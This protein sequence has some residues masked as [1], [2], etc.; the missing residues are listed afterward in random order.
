M[1]VRDRVRPRERLVAQRRE[2][3]DRGIERAHGELDA[4]LIVPLAGAAVRGRVGA[5]L[6]RGLDQERCDQRARE[7]RRERIDPFVER[8]RAH[9]GESEFG[10]QAFFRIDDD[11]VVGAEVERLLLDLREFGGGAAAGRAVALAEIERQ[12]DHAVARVDVFLEEYRGI[13]PTG[14]GQDDR[15][16]R[17]PSSVS[18]GRMS[19]KRCM[20]IGV[21]V[22]ASRITRTVSSPAIVP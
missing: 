6:L 3:L 10:E 21:L 5:V 17:V 13:E 15:A 14:V 8:V 19:L 16:H 18:A 2:R 20:T 11:G 22:T 9:R 4:D 12:R 1:R 7:R